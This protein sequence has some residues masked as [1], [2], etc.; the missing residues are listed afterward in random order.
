MRPAAAVFYALLVRVAVTTGEIMTVVVTTGAD[1]PPRLTR[2]AERLVTDVPE[3]TSLLLNINAKRTNVIL[4]PKWQL[5]H[6]RPTITD[7]LGPYRFHI[8]GGI[9]L[10]GQSLSNCSLVRTS[11]DLCR[12]HGERSS[13]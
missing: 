5:L 2:L 10:S 6:G 1:R 9:V 13:C 7:Y 4:G 12:A 3:L 11:P 8:S